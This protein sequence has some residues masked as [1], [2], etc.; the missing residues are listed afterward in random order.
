MHLE[1]TSW[2]RGWEYIVIHAI[3]D[4]PFCCTVSVVVVKTVWYMVLKVLQIANPFLHRKLIPMNLNHTLEFPI[5]SN[6][7]IYVFPC[8]S[9]YHQEYSKVVGSHSRL[10]EPSMGLIAWPI[11]GS[12]ML[13]R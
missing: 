13:G 12:E 7:P 1:H 2:F 8:D 5:K 9:M 10:L 6:A 4:K 11:K 3:V